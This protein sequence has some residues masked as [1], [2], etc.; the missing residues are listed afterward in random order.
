MSKEYN[1]GELYCAI[2]QYLQEDLSP[3]VDCWKAELSEHARKNLQRL[4]RRKTW[5][6]A[7]DDI[8]KMLG[9]RK[10]LPLSRMHHIMDTHCDEVSRVF[11]STGF[12]TA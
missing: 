1:Q 8:L 7:F 10:G 2:R 6:S 3:M 9:L 5:Q 4:L 11:L 12:L